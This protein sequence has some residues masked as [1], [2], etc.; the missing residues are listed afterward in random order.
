[1][2]FSHLASDA[3]D[4]VECSENEEEEEVVGG[5]DFTAEEWGEL[6]KFEAQ[7]GEFSSS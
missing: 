4:K 2:F 5:D 3:D 6:D 1:M 7:R